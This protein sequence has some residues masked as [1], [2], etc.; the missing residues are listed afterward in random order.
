MSRLFFVLVLFFAVLGWS[1]DYTGRCYAD[2][3]C[4][5]NCERCSLPT[6]GNNTYIAYQ[7]GDR[8]TIN[9]NAN[10]WVT[11]GYGFYQASCP[12]MGYCSNKYVDYGCFN[13][14]INLDS[15]N[16]LHAGN[17]WIDGTCCD[18]RCLCEKEGHQWNEST[19]SCI[20]CN[21]HVD[22]PD[23]CMEVWKQGYMTDSE[24]NPG[25]GGYWAIE[26][27]TCFYDSCAM[28]LNCTPKSSFPAGTLTCDDFQDTTSNNHCVA[29]IGHQCTIQ[30]GNNVTKNCD[31]D[32]SCEHAKTLSACKCP[33][34]SSSQNNSSSSENGSS[35]SQS[36]S[37]SSSSQTSS[38][39]NEG[40]NSSGSP[41]DTTGNG[42]WEYNYSGVLNEIE[43]NTRQTANNT[44]I[45]AG[46]LSSIDRWQSTI[47]FNIQNES[48]KIQGSIE[49]GATQ[50]ATAVN[51]A[52]DSIHSTNEILSDIRGSLGSFDD[53]TDVPDISGWLDSASGTLESLK[54]PDTTFVRVDSLKSD[55]STFKSKY[56]S[57][58]LTGVYTRNGC[59]EFKMT[60]PQQNSKFGRAFS[61]DIEVDFGSLA[62][63]FD[64]CAIFRGLCR[65]AGAIL[66]LLISIKSYRSAFSSSDG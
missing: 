58:F 63:I 28:S 65:I 51:G 20:S 55:T 5:L 36:E 14:P 41:V 25:G 1:Y 8:I 2:N 44:N 11:G 39:S 45:A 53:S 62:G 10:C 56:S 47:N 15:L 17:Q 27:Y 37:S 34:S 38:S 32:G 49:S 13:S 7:V 50:V 64:L 43:W 24:G 57:M 30:C 16:C 60:K 42:D 6:G 40:P 3:G 46:Y 29:V 18:A 31:C 21:D 59:Y 26:T 9:N 33:Q 66:V 35:S 52:K 54:N 23:K 19:N 48:N 61:K 12:S 4:G 22:V